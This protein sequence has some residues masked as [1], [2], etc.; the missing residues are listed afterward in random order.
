M[1]ELAT[2]MLAEARTQLPS[3]VHAALVAR[4]IDGL[5]SDAPPVTELPTDEEVRRHA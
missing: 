4:L 3:H 2:R 1:D 5:L